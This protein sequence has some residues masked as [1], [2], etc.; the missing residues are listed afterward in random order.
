[1]QQRAK[2]LVLPVEERIFYATTL[3]S[4][5]TYKVFTV[6]V[7]PHWGFNKANGKAP[8]DRVWLTAASAL[9]VILYYI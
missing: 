3:N 4:N 9:E 2:F 5:C 6:L 1:M 8:T 7:G